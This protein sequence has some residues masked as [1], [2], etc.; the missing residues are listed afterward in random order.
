MRLLIDDLTLDLDARRLLRGREE[1]HLSPKAYEL[2]RI[3]VDR[4]PR[5]LSKR[6]LHEQLWPETFVSETNLANLIVEIRNAL[7]ESARA[8]RY[9]R[10][11]Q[12]YGYAFNGEVAEQTAGRTSFC[13][14]VLDGKRLPLR[15]GDNIIGR[16]ADDGSGTSRRRCRGATHAS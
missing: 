2:F 3:L 15:P 6:E 1:L 5:A 14:L 4:R 12:R 10:T 7:G 8:P 9:V 11:V 13:W 16:D